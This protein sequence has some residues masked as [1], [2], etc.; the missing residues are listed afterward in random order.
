M[1][2]CNGQKSIPEEPLDTVSELHDIWLLKSI[3]PM[4]LPAETDYKDMK[5]P[6]LEVHAADR[7]IYGNDGCNDI[8]GAITI[9]EPN[10][11]SFGNIGATKKFCPNMILPN[12]FNRTLEMVTAYQREK[13]ELVFFDINANEIMR[14][15]K[16]D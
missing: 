12:T 11:I 9:L 8:F 7:K 4:G 6:I 10:L 16:I 14:F 3:S 15:Q 2:S 5:M 13:L 1:L